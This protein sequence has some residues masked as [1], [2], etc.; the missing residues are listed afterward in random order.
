MKCRLTAR[1][2][3]AL[4]LRPIARDALRFGRERRS[5]FAQVQQDARQGS[6][7]SIALLLC[8]ALVGL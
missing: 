8:L 6:R 3:L 4:G 2:A 5:L 1:A 7:V